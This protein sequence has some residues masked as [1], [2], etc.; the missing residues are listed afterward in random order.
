MPLAGLK[1]AHTPRK[2]RCSFPHPASALAWELC[3][4]SYNGIYGV[5]V[6]VNTRVSHLALNHF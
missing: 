2:A 3:Q 5:E 1:P 6:S 4:L